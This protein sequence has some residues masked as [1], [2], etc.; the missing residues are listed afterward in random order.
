MATASCTNI[1]DVT[2]KVEPH[3]LVL[4]RLQPAHFVRQ[5][6]AIPL[7]RWSPEIGH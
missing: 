2:R 4:E 1:R 6:A 7:L 5:Q 3:V